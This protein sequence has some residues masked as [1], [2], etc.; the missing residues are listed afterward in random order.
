MLVLLGEVGPA[1]G[2]WEE[3]LRLKEQIGDV[4]GKAATL[5]NMAGVVAQQGDV[6]RAMGLWEESLRLDEQI[7]DVG[8]KA[9]TL[10]NMAW[11]AGREGAG[12]RQRRLNLEAAGLLASVQAWN[13]LVT[14]LGNLGA[15]GDTAATGFLAQA[16]WLSLR[17]EVPLD[18]ILS[19]AAALVDRLGPSSDVAPLIATAGLFMVQVRGEG[20]PQQEKMHELGIHLALACAAARDIPE[21]KLM[22]WLDA[23]GLRDPSRFLPALDLAIA[24]TVGD[25]GWL[26]DRQLFAG[27]R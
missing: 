22:E 15:A 4:G 7:G 5:A 21:D 9:A 2:V 1:L 8:G 17:I 27:G 26:F 19:L 16:V 24:T 3:S 11:L 12:E 23:E 10:A 13:D 14:V 20:H 6:Q 18:S 25:D